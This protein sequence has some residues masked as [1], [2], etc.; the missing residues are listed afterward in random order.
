MSAACSLPL[1]QKLARMDAKG[2]KAYELMRDVQSAQAAEGLNVT[3]TYVANPDKGVRVH[4][5]GGGQTQVFLGRSP[6]VRRTG[7]GG[8]GDNRKVLDFWMPQL[9]VRR[10][11]PAPFQSAFAAVHEPFDGKPFIESVTALPLAPPDPS[12][13]AL[14]VNNGDI[15]DTILSTLDDSPMAADGVQLKGRLGIVRRQA[16]KVAGAWLFEG[17]SLSGDGFSLK[18]E[19]ERYTGEI[20]AATRKADDAPHD[21]FITDAALPLGDA[22]RGAWM[23]VTHGNG[24][25]HGYQID[26]IEKSA[27]GNGLR[28][29]PGTLI[30][31]TDD[32]GL[33]IDAAVTHE[34]YFPQRKMEGKNTF[35]IPLATTMVRSK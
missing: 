28:A 25:T 26:H 35:V 4:L 17:Q 20:V 14:R 31:L 6:S 13:V 2:V 1:S 24:Y 12:A 3:F 30:V 32:H 27:V 11:G 7:I 5:L 23:I 8:R 34:V 16:G 22:L 10:T 15:V 18:A 21:A 29:V 33:K 9:V 19:R